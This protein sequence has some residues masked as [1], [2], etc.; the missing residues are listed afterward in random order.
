M[1]DYDLVEVNNFDNC[2]HLTS[3]TLSIINDLTEQVSAPTYSKTPSFPA[4]STS[5][6][7]NTTSAS[8]ST[9][10]ASSSGSSDLKGSHIHKGRSGHYSKQSSSS[11]HYKKTPSSSD[12]SRNEDKWRSNKTTFQPTKILR[13]KGGGNGT[14]DETRMLL[15][16]LTEK[17]YKKISDQI[18][19]IVDTIESR[20]LKIEIMEQIVNV[21]C[22]NSINCESYAKLL[23]ETRSLLGVTEGECIK[24]MITKYSNSFEELIGVT[25]SPD[26]D[27]DKFCEMNVINNKRKGKTQFLCHLT[28]NNL[29]SESEI[30]KIIDDMIGLLKDHLHN[31]DALMCNEEITDNIFIISKYAFNKNPETTQIS[32]II[33]RIS[34]EDFSGFTKTKHE[35]ITQKAKFKVM[36]IMDMIKKH[37]NK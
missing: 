15:N 30:I 1:K 18:V 22:A 4:Q 17:T 36:D 31:N 28:E 21:A 13:N 11:S 9:K 12:N 14:I 23:H 8:T 2:S 29:V 35:G 33:K 34:S 20:D 32:S 3:M 10:Y 24:N 27:Y 19:D 16:K 37:K 5:D 7:S 26:E 25:S 6:K